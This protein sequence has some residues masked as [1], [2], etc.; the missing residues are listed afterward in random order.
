MMADG[1]KLTGFKELADALRE[2]GP[3][4]AR[5]SLRRAVSAGAAEIRNDAKARA[6]VDTGEMRKDI[7]IKRE[8]DT[9]GEMAATYSVFVRSGKKSRLAGKSRDVQKDSY[10]WKF[11]EF[12]TSKM[13]AKPFLRPAFESR[14]EEAVKVIGEKLD[15]GVQ[16]AARELAGTR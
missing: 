15:E 12:G 7:M 11:V 2:L 3:R 8:R 1:L 10:Y 6:P 4:V 13:A 16:K 5:N 9:K 14:K